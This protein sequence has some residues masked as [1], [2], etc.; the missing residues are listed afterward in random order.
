MKAQTRESSRDNRPQPFPHESL[1]SMLCV[2]VETEIRRAESASYNLADVHHAN[3][4]ASVAPPEEMADDL[5]PPTALQVPCPAQRRTR[6]I[7]PRTM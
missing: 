7:D 4:L 3:E 6:R 5:A 2:G 1:T